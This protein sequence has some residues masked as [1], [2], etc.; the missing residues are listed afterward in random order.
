M[1]STATLMLLGAL[2]WAPITVASEFSGVATLTSEYIY[3]GLK[4]SNGDPA[5]QM[6]LD[7]EHDTGLFVGVF[8]NQASFAVE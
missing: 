2:A 6:G 5:L 3:R 1:S 8:V 4:M 7:Y